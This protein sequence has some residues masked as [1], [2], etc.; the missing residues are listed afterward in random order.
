MPAQR[1]RTEVYTPIHTYKSFA[2][3]N[4]DDSTQDYDNYLRL[5]HLGVA[6]LYAAPEPPAISQLWKVYEGHGIQG[7]LTYV[8]ESAA[9]TF[10]PWEQSLE[11]AIEGLEHQSLR[12]LHFDERLSPLL[13][14]REI[15]YSLSKMAGESASNCLDGRNPHE[16]WLAMLLGVCCAKV[17]VYV[18]AQ[19]PFKWTCIKY[20]EH[21]SKQPQGCTPSSPVDSGDEGGSCH[22][23][24]VPVSANEA[25]MSDMDANGE[26]CRG[27]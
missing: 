10:F 17:R 9:G 24:F 13:K 19:H 26:E 27:Y 4:L 15:L 2:S 11:E 22:G 23:S 25:D 18:P 7:L 1:P 8:W 6:Q 3:T 21:E 20:I 16:V 14:D 5:V 12:P